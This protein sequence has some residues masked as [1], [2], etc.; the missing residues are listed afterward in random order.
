M[1]NSIESIIL[2]YSSERGAKEEELRGMLARTQ[3]FSDAGYWAKQFF[4]NPEFA[5]KFQDLVANEDN[6]EQSL[7]SLIDDP[8]KMEALFGGEQDEKE[9]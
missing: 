5:S 1:K 4:A 8:E 3:R 2:Y 6:I 9:W 7:Q